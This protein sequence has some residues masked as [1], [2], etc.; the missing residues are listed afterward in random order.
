MSSMSVKAKSCLVT[1][2]LY[3]VFSVI[4][5]LSLKFGVT[6]LYGLDNL[7]DYR[8]DFTNSNKYKLLRTSTDLSQQTSFIYIFLQGLGRTWGLT[9]YYSSLVIKREA[10]ENTYII[11]WIVSALFVALEIPSNLIKPFCPLQSISPATLLCKRLMQSPKHNLYSELGMIMATPLFPFAYLNVFI[12]AFW[13][14]WTEN[15]RK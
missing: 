11:S 12:S 4:Q 9:E 15:S 1:C 3:K 10:I 5:H 14:Y 13:V 7:N 6:G 2:F 8:V